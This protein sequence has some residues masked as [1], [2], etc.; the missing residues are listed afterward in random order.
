[1][2]MRVSAGQVPVELVR[3]MYI[4]LVGRGLLNHRIG[5]DHVMIA[6]GWRLQFAR[7]RVRINKS[8]SCHHD[9]TGDINSPLGSCRLAGGDVLLVW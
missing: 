7:S 9:A 3:C 1:M 2:W 5:L 4:L 8:V 6:Q